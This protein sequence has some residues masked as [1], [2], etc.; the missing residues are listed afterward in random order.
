MSDNNTLNNEN[1]SNGAAETPLM[2]WAVASDDKQVETMDALINSIP[3][4]F[5]PAFRNRVDVL[6]RAN[7]AKMR[8]SLVD[9]VKAIDAQISELNGQRN[10]L[11]QQ[12]SEYDGIPDEADSKT[13]SNSNSSPLKP[14]NDINEANEANAANGAN[15]ANEDSSE[16]DTS[17][18]DSDLKATYVTT[19]ST[20]NKKIV[21]PK[22]M[23]KKEKAPITKSKAINTVKFRSEK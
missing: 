9:Q 3:T 13:T 21:N 6:I 19:K 1:D 5:W 4:D 7:R 14:T 11:N 15:E 17:D 20:L 2:D 18:D 23:K 16:I 22:N 8:Q 12:I 10:R